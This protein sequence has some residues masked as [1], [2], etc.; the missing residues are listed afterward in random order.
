[1]SRSRWVLRPP[2]RA[3]AVVSPRRGPALRRLEPRARAGGCRFRESV[4]PGKAGQGGNGVCDDPMKP[5]LSSSGCETRPAKGEPAR[6][7]ASLAPETVTDSAKRRH[8]SEWAVGRAAGA[9]SARQLP[10][11][12]SPVRRRRVRSIAEP[13]KPSSKT[14][15][16]MCAGRSE[17]AVSGCVS[18]SVIKA[19]A[20]RV[21][22]RRV[23]AQ[24]WRECGCRAPEPG[25]VDRVP[26]WLVAASAVRMPLFPLSTPIPARPTP[27]CHRNTRYGSVLPVTEVLP[28]GRMNSVGNRSG[29]RSESIRVGDRSRT[30]RRPWDA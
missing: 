19:Y 28:S 16:R 8:A 25:T 21:K 11:C 17:A 5:C 14:R 26:G 1:M 24:R 7:V 18:E 23:V 4:R 3:T 30:G 2:G 10:E 6:P 29:W 12:A 20:P 9:G 27:Q 22:A 13:S 15:C